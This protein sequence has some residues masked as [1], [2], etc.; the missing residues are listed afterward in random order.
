M[1]RILQIV[2]PTQTCAHTT[3]NTKST[4]HQICSHRPISRRFHHIVL[5][6]IPLRIQLWIQYCGI[7]EFFDARMAGNRQS[8]QN[9]S[10]QVSCF[11]NICSASHDVNLP[12]TDKFFEL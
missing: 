12:Y 8:S 10:L 6:Y 9:L 5:R 4:R 1:A 3:I 11:L 7:R 2:Y